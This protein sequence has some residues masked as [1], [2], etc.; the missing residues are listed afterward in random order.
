M[1][2]PFAIPPNLR[3]MGRGRM[4]PE[5]KS[6]VQGDMAKLAPESKMTENDF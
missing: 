3:S 2:K 5:T 6:L 4:D 1:A